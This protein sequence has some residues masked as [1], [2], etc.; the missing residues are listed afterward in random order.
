M[1]RKQKPM[2]MY[3][4]FLNNNANNARKER[5]LTSEKIG[6]LYFLSI[7][8]KLTKDAKR[9]CRIHDSWPPMPTK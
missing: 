9:N 2:L 7:K 6:F 3:F 8:E 4:S 5:H 1:R